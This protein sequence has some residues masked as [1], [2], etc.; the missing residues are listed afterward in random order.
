MM[1]DIGS[2]VLSHLVAGDSIAFI[3][4]FHL[5]ISISIIP[6]RVYISFFVSLSTASAFQPPHSFVMKKV[7]TTLK[8]FPEE[9]VLQASKSSL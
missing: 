5:F 7:L 9:T 6:T 8:C 4:L 3:T 1:H 2:L